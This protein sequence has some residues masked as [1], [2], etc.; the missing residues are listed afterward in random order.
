VKD[1]SRLRGVLRATV[2]LIDFASRHDWAADGIPAPTWAREL[3]IR[4]HADQADHDVFVLHVIGFAVLPPKYWDMT[5]IHEKLNH[6]EYAM[7]VN[8]NISLPM[9]R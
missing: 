2:I 6:F 7:I 9:Q 4:I 5:T 1:H 3:R 8:I